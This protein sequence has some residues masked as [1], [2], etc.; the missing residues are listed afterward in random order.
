MRHHADGCKNG[1]IAREA[2][3]IGNERRKN[4][5]SMACSKSGGDV[6]ILKDSDGDEQSYCQSKKDKSLASTSVF[7][8]TSA[9]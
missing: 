4:P 5:H 9:D 1:E 2:F 3:G 8:W 7:M 6:R